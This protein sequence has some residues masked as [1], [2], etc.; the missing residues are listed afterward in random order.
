MFLVI[1][2]VLSISDILLNPASL[3]LISQVQWNRAKKF[4]VA[5]HSAHS[6][7]PGS[8]CYT[9]W[10]RVKYK[11]STFN[12]EITPNLLLNS[13]GKRKTIFETWIWNTICAILLSVY[14]IFNW[15]GLYFLN[16]NFVQNLLIW[17]INIFIL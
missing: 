12:A 15:N 5:R 10:W 3:L 9:L 8:F 17:I 6:A 1:T 7:F 13:I 16:W 2:I 14:P 4:W 11:T